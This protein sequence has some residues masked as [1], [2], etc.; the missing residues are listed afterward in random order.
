MKSQIIPEKAH[1]EKTETESKSQ[2]TPEKAP[3]G[4]TKTSS[5]LPSSKSPDFVF[6]TPIKTVAGLLTTPSKTPTRLETITS[7]ED[8][9]KLLSPTTPTPVPMT[10][11][12]SSLSQPAPAPGP[13][14]HSS[15]RYPPY[16][17]ALQ[18]MQQPGPQY[19][20]PWG[21]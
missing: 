8:R 10:R 14:S 21:Y 7:L 17:G 18:T 2:V 5:G 1:E 13:V 6:K 9:A 20:A 19:T 15:P 16:S 3:E 12:V 11:P 4:N